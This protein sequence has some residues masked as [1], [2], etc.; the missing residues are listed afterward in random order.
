MKINRK[1]LRRLI[2]SVINEEGL[3]DLGLPKNFNT[4]YTS[5]ITSKLFDIIQNPKYAMDK[6]EEFVQLLM[7]DPAVSEEEKKGI[8]QLLD[9]VKEM[10]QADKMIK[11]I[12]RTQVDDVIKDVFGSDPLNES[13]MSGLDLPVDMSGDLEPIDQN[14]KSLPEMVM[15]ALRVGLPEEYDCVM[16]EDGLGVAKIECYGDDQGGELQFVIQFQP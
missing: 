7:K 8:Q 6:K 14:K 2:E 1:H 16:E 11:D 10:A 13:A 12:E 3:A 5:E 15:E 9:A 4:V